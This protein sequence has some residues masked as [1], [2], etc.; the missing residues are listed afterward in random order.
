MLAR[1]FQPLP[2][3]GPL[4]PFPFDVNNPA[5]LAQNRFD[6]AIDIAAMLEIGHTPITGSAPR[7]RVSDL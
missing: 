1:H 2:P 6:A 4:D 5:G 7:H 3:L